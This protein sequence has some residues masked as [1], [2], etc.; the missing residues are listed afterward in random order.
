MRHG[1]FTESAK[2]R[3][4]RGQRRCVGQVF[5]QVVWV[6]LVHKIFVWVKKM[7]W[8]EIMAKVAWV[9]WVHKILA[10]VKNWRGSNKWR[11]LKLC[12][13][14]KNGMGLNVLLFNDTLQ[15]TFSS[16]ETDLIVPMKFNKLYSSSSSYLIYFVLL[17]LFKNIR[18]SAIMLILQAKIKKQT[19]LGY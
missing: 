3:G 1:T 15:K 10:L 17:S 7:V 9:V 11:E 5:A 18:V 8:V 13:Q 19:D 12:R 4:W 14:L 6:A 16:V 2:Q